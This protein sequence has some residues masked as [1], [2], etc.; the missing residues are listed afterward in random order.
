MLNQE[1]KGEIDMSEIDLPDTRLV[2][3]CTSKPRRYYG[4]VQHEA[5]RS[6]SHCFS[7][8]RLTA[9]LELKEKENEKLKRAWDKVQKA[10]DVVTGRGVQIR[11][12]YFETQ[13]NTLSNKA[14][15]QAEDLVKIG[16]ALEQETLARETI[17]QERDASVQNGQRWKEG[18]EAFEKLKGD[19]ALAQKNL[20][21][22]LDE[23]D[24]LQAEVETL[25]KSIADLEE[26]LKAP[27][28]PS[29]EEVVRIEHNTEER[30]KSHFFEAYEL[31]VDEG[32]A[33]YYQ[34]RFTKRF[35][36]VCLGEEAKKAN[37]PS[38]E[39]VVTPA[40]SDD[41]EE[42]EEADEAEGEEENKEEPVDGASALVSEEPVQDKDSA[43]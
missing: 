31:M 40:T 15:R 27:R 14:E 20:K 11:R 3:R 16:K 7:F 4:G 30:L 17:R 39:L 22:A 12:T 41:E 9:F 37:Q 24:S 25:K 5:V 34:E 38:P 43:K 21:K 33:A 1:Q 35:N 10:Q 36:F 26:Q 42:E 18:F 13:I 29:A 28:P 8:L 6:I 23:V 2:R 19:V 32:E